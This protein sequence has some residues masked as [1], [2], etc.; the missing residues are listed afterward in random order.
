ML[1]RSTISLSVGQTICCLSR[2]PHLLCSMLKRSCSEEAAVKS[3][4]GIETNPKEMVPE[5]MARAAMSVML[6]STAT[7][8]K[9]FDE[10]RRI[11]RR[12]SHT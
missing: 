3:F 10:N 11:Q 2:P 1:S 7:L 5:A 6:T 8:E 12:A 9:E 4:T